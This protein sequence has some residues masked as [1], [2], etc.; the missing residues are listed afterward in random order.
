MDYH[1]RLAGA[2]L[3]CCLRCR[4]ERFRSHPWAPCL[5]C[6]RDEF[7]AGVVGGAGTGDLP[8]VWRGCPGSPHYGQAGGTIRL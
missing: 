3:T 4:A 2:A 1:D 6:G 5:E 8:E 7:Y